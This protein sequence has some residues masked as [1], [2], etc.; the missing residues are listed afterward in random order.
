MR[1]R[2]LVAAVSLFLLLAGCSDKDRP[3]QKDVKLT[4]RVYK[5]ALLKVQGYIEATGTIQHDMEGGTKIVSPVPG[6]VERIFVKFGERVQAGTPLL[7]IRSID[8]NDAYTGYQASLAQLK[9]AERLYN[10]NQKLFEIGSVT[11]NDLLSAAVSYTHLTLPT[12][13]IV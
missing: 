10:L 5:V 11:R 9:Q 12:K 4:P 3:P 7:S 8:V 2:I 6:I 13:R 1:R